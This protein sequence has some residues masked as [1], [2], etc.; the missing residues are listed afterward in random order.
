M[1][2]KFCFDG[3]NNLAYN[4]YKSALL[5][6]RQYKNIIRQNYIYFGE[7]DIKKF[8]DTEEGTLHWI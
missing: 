2:K 6:I 5:I 7:T 1:I 3:K 4:D 8:T